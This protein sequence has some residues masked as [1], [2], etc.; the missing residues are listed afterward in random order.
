V[1]A[2]SAADVVSPLALG[3][4]DAS[5][6]SVAALTDGTGEGDELLVLELL[7]EHAVTTAAQKTSKSR[8]AIITAS[9]R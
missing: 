9:V 6:T 1:A 5:P 7:L 2:T 8:R 4:A 3:D